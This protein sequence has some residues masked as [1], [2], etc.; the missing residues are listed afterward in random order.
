[1]ITICCAWCLFASQPRKNESFLFLMKLFNV[2]SVDIY[3]LL[4]L[5]SIRLNVRFDITVK[6]SDWLFGLVLEWNGRWRWY[7]FSLYQRVFFKCKTIVLIES[8]IW[9]N[10]KVE[11]VWKS[12]FH[13]EKQTVLKINGLVSFLNAWIGRVQLSNRKWFKYHFTSLINV[14]WWWKEF[15]IH[16]MNEFMQ[17]W[18][19][20]NNFLQFSC[21]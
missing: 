12:G 19:R 6:T 9:L 15:I 7:L 21:I 16:L 1:M 2:I 17:F 8:I 20:P 3:T 10:H 4:S 11:N 13:E 18:C 5:Y 14:G